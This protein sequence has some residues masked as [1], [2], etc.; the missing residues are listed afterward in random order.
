MDIIGNPTVQAYGEMRQAYDY[1]NNQLF[2]GTLPP[3]LITLY[4]LRR[5]LGHFCRSRFV[6]LADGSE[7]TDEIAFDPAHFLGCDLEQVLS[8]LAHEMTQLWQHH[9]GKSSRSGHHNREW[10]ERMKSIGLCPSST[11]QPG[12]KETGQRMSHFIMAGG[13][14]ERTTAELLASGFALTWA[15]PEGDKPGGKSGKR[16]KY[17]CPQCHVNAWAKPNTRLSCDDCCQSMLTEST[18]LLERFLPLSD[19]HH[20]IGT[21]S[22]L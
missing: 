22:Q 1:Y 6:R 9:F 4:R 10:A 17:T 7:F 14:F 20:N 5:A 11:G 2:A 16:I 12:G 21:E 13:A 8:T 3:C 19:V 18:N 15:I